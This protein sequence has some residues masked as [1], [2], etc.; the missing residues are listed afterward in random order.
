[1]SSSKDRQERRRAREEAARGRE[2]DDGRRRTRRVLIGGVATFALVGAIAAALVAS[3]GND[4]ARSSPAAA[5]KIDTTGL[6]PKLAEHA[7]DAN[8]VIDSEILA[9]LTTLEGIPVVVNQWASWCPNC[10]SEFGFFAELANRYRDKVAFIGLDSRDDRGKAED[11]L[12]DHPLP[13]L[14]IYDENAAQASS[15]G[16][17]QNWPTTMFYNAD[18]K[19]TFVRPGGYTT[20]QSLDDDIRLYALEGSS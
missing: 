18:G 2:Q 15:I 20:I 12:K 5:V 13:F 3:G 11:F 16:G 10:K 19:R 7:R 1:M 8:R 6:P 4:G 17:G 14:S 9:K